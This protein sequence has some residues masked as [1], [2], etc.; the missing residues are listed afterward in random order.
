MTPI[1]QT[2]Y[3]KSTGNCLT[4]C[5][6][7]LIDLPIET[8]PEF[9]I[10]GI[11]F[12]KLAEFCS[13]NGYSLIYFKH[14]VNNQVIPINTLL[15]ACMKLVNTEDLHSIIVRTK[16]NVEF[17]ASGETKWTWI[18][19]IVHDPNQNGVPEMLEPDYYIYIGKQ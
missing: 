5:V 15:I 2:N 8:V 11:W 10:D 14:G 9:C 19:E 13:T 7:S 12:T 16:P 4:A 3:G 1:Y 18:A 6:A 17:L